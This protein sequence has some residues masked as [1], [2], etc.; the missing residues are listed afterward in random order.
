MVERTRASLLCA[1]RHTICDP[2][3]GKGDRVTRWGRLT[4]YVTDVDARWTLSARNLRTSSP[5]SFSQLGGQ[6]VHRP[7]FRK[8]SEPRVGTCLARLGLSIVMY[9][10]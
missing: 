3:S 5:L 1:Q 7:K 2:Q 4:F 9:C 6:R 8:P 10:I